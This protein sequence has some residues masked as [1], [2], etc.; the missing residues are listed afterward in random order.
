MKLKPNPSVSEEFKYQISNY[1]LVENQFEY[2]NFVSIFTSVT[3][4]VPLYLIMG[5]RS[6]DILQLNL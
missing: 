6:P 1:G 3:D 2:T 4:C 5:I